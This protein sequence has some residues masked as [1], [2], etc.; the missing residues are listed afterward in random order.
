MSTATTIQAHIAYELIEDTNHD[1]V[2]IEFQSHD[3]ASPVHAHELGEQ[4]NSLI[5][6]DSDHYFVIDFAGVRSLGSTAF[7]EIVSFVRKAAPV[8]VCNLDTTLQLGA[9][10]IGLDDCAKFAADRRAAINEALRAVRR[11]EE[12]TIDYP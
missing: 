4:L 5:R 8:W 11:N 2:V 6:P 9:S 12:D 7:G 10:L 3:I 1:V